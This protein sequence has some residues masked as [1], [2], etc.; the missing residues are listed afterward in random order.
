M[1]AD[2][3]TEQRVLAA[4]DRQFAGVVGYVGR[5][6]VDVG[7]TTERSVDARRGV[8]VPQ[9]QFPLVVTQI[10]RVQ[11]ADEELL[12]GMGGYVPILHHLDAPVVVAPL[13]KIPCCWYGERA[14]G[15]A[16]SGVLGPTLNVMNH[17]CIEVRG[18]R[19]LEDDLVVADARCVPLEHRSRVPSQVVTAVHPDTLTV[20][21]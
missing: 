13:L 6:A 12:R 2:V 17:T 7:V 21:R 16:D 4:R 5:Q 19:Q 15:R 11:L 8:A 14:R 20:E 10:G 3:A 9:A 18:V 1:A